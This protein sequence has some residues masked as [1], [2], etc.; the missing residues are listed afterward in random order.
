MFAEGFD[1]RVA[2]MGDLVFT[3]TEETLNQA[4]R[5]LRIGERWFKN[6]QVEQ[7]VWTQFFFLTEHN[8]DWNKGVP[9]TWIPEKWKNLLFVLQKV[10]TYEGQYVVAFLYH[11]LLLLHFEFNDHLNFPFYLCQIL[12]RMA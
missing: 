9:T 4:T 11:I 2:H 6:K 3:V 10:I 12:G 5:L 8:S 1:G 7:G